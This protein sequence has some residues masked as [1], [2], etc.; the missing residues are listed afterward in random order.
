[1][2]TFLYHYSPLTVSVNA[3]SWQD[4]DGGLHETQVSEKLE[5]VC[6]LFLQEASSSIIVMAPLKR[7]I[8]LYR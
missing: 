1:M 2:Q 4:Y 7:W 5:P 8:M 3:R 6:V